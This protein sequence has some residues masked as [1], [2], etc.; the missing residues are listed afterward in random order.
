MRA[1]L[2]F[3]P[4]REPIGPVPD[5]GADLLARI[6]TI[7]D[8]TEGVFLT[9]GS[10]LIELASLLDTA[11]QGAVSLDKITRG[12]LLDRLHGEAEGQ[13]ASFGELTRGFQKVDAGIEALAHALRQL[14]SD[15]QDVRR[16]V[17]TMRMVVLDARVT[18]AS[19]HAQDQRLSNF[20]EDGQAV[21]TQIVD[22]L[23]RFE[24]AMPTMRGIVDDTA[25][26]V[27]DI[28]DN[29]E[30]G[31][32]VAFGQLMRDVAAF[33]AGARAA[34]GQGHA[35]S[36]KLQTLLG[37]TAAAVSGLQVGDSTRQQLDHAAFIL[38]LPEAGDPALRALAEALVIDVSA[39]HGRTLD[40]LR[41]SVAKMIAGLKDLFDAHLGGFL[42]ACGQTA[43]PA[44]LREASGRL[45]IA[46]KALYPLQAKA[47]SLERAMAE[48]FDA[49]RGL[50]STGEKV[51]QS[52]RQIG[53][54]AVL[55]CSRL[56]SGGQALKVVAE[57]LQC[58]A[59]DVG[60]RFAAMRKTLDGVGLLRQ[61]TTSAIDRAL[62]NSIEMPERLANTMDPL[63]SSV[64]DCLLPVNTAVMQLRDRLAN[65]DIDFGPAQNHRAQL[66][67][68]ADGLSPMRRPP[69]SDRVS[70]ETL[71][72][73]ARV[74][75]IERERDVF[76]AIL[77][78]RASLLAG[79]MT[80]AGFGLEDDGFLL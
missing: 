43:D 21:V 31:V 40:E 30:K 19:L 34:S 56:G 46:I 8:A 20:A 53:I 42:D 61:E 66:Q 47:Q 3:R 49:F 29:L 73:I 48:E 39:V 26:A 60:H 25:S 69:V 76:R 45:G 22:L 65:L 4:G 2:A 9:T 32:I 5:R 58:V 15:L 68:L 41:Q 6:V 12:G 11:R 14:G 27:R 52:T 78:D 54:N 51:Q 59:R 7:R 18:L 24:E 55:S 62:R 35:L 50:I 38:S 1:E 23:A 72:R 74:F 80:G 36:G 64:T 44:F 67:T 33:E 37:A 13:T 70:D 57:Q 63:I 16:S 77:P 10:Q 17:V 79:P 75:T 71:G 28:G